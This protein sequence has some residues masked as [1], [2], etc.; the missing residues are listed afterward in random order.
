M[1]LGLTR[2]KSCTFCSTDLIDG[3][4]VERV[5]HGEVAVDLPVEG[6]HSTPGRNG[7]GLDGFER[8]LSEINSNYSSVGQVKFV[9][10]YH[11]FRCASLVVVVVFRRV[12]W[13]LESCKPFG[14][15]ATQGIAGKLKSARKKLRIFVVDLN[16]V[17]QTYKL[18][19]IIG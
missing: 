17:K 19:H 1:A 5:R 15:G 9:L 3:P 18:L 4:L 13:P 6:S 8:L 14:A 11:L 2:L 7:R 10:H 16:S 12:G